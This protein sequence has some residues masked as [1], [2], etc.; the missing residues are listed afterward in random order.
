MMTRGFA[1]AKPPKPQHSWEGIED[2]A[3]PVLE[4]QGLAP[5]MGSS[6]GKNGAKSPWFSRKKKTKKTMVFDRKK[7]LQIDIKSHIYAPRFTHSHVADWWLSNLDP[8]SEGKHLQIGISTHFTS[9]L[10]WDFPCFFCTPKGSL[11]WS[12]WNM[13]PR[14]VCKRVRFHPK[15]IELGSYLA[16]TIVQKHL[17]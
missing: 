9:V 13:E 12:I 10:S 6:I 7:K 3:P 8:K 5:R 14:D 11:S 1:N 15:P 17:C 2:D 16:E 4:Q